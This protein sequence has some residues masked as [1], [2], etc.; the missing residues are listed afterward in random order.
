MLVTGMQMHQST[1]NTGFFKLSL[2]GPFWSFGSIGGEGVA[3]ILRSVGCSPEEI[4]SLMGAQVPHKDG[5]FVIQPP[6]QTLL[7]MPKETRSKLYLELA[8][9]RENIFQAN[10]VLI[11]RSTLPGQ[12]RALVPN[13][14]PLCQMI[15]KLSYPRNGYTY[16][17]DPEVLW[18]LMGGGEA[19]K[20]S[21]LKFLTSIPTVSASL[22]IKPD[23]QIDQS[24]IY[25]AL[26]MP[27]VRVSDLY[28][29]F[30]SQKALP[31]GGLIPISYLLPAIARNS[32]YATPLPFQG[33][34]EH[35]VDCLSTALMFF[36]PD[37]DPR[38]SDP[39]FAFKFVRGHYYEISRPSLAGDLVLLLNDKGILV[40]AAVHLAGDIV[41][42]KNGVSTSQP[43]VLM[44]EKDM[45]ALFSAL[46]PI[47]VYYMRWNDW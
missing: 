12:L 16:F 24:I 35:P 45:V 15:D 36:A 6:E 23:T 10:P 3:Q 19:E 22:L 20:E 41:Y 14:A 2:Q 9:N 28:P 38:V 42:G 44:H 29:L 34:G 25:W 13:P 46:S 43:W 7:S 33:K 26:P 18:R 4:K 8:K 40:H 1:E 30:E 47:K 27:G 21:L 17:S 39:E 32:L 37:P 11:D 31:Q 5:S